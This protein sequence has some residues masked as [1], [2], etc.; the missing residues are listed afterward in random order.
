MSTG[1]LRDVNAKTNLKAA[2]LLLHDEVKKG[3]FS[4]VPIMLWIWTL[5]ESFKQTCTD[6]FFDFRFFM[7]FIQH[8]FIFRPSDST[9]S[10]DAGIEPKTVATLTFT[11]IRSNLSAESHLFQLLLCS[12][13]DQNSERGC[14]PFYPSMY[15]FS[16]VYEVPYGV[17]FTDY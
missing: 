2:N 10:E 11:S 17:K 15:F 6:V 4:R 12:P 8:F 16:L 3:C 13:L 14:T 1:K 9:V 7:Y 5:M